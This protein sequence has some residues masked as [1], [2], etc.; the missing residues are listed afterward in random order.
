MQTVAG[1]IIQSFKEKLVRLV[2]GPITGTNLQAEDLPIDMLYRVYPIN[3]KDGSVRFIQAPVDEVKDFQREVLKEV[4]ELLPI[5]PCS[6]ASAGE[7]ILKNA[8]K[9]LGAKHILKIDITKFYENCTYHKV[10]RYLERQPLD[11]V[12]ASIYE[13]LRSNKGLFFYHPLYRIDGITKKSFRSPNSVFEYKPLWL[14]TGGPMSPWL[15]NWAVADIDLHFMDLQKQTPGMVYTRYLDDLT[16]SF[17]ETPPEK[18]FEDAISVVTDAGWEVNWRKSGFLNRNNDQWTVTGIGLEEGKLKVPR[19]YKQKMRTLLNRR[20]RELADRFIPADPSMPTV[21]K[22]GE[23]DDLL[24]VSGMGC[25]EFIRQIDKQE[26]INI[27]NYFKKRLMI[28][29]LKRAQDIERAYPILSH[30]GFTK[31]ISDLILQ[32]EAL[33]FD[34]LVDR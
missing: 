14:P 9:H 30:P 27:T 2:S 18:F 20:S 15:S 24:E 31:E 22:I 25:L 34:H 32:V 1:P 17:K 29:V 13:L 12:E 16:F 10:V 23:I 26:F 5:L 7:G 4:T 28:A 8:E 21:D 11:S 6:M 33:K 19:Y 3:K